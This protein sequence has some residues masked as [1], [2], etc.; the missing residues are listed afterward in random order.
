MGWFSPGGEDCGPL[1]HDIGSTVLRF[2][3]EVNHTFQRFERLISD[4]GSTLHNRKA[5]DDTAKEIDKHHDGIKQAIENARRELEE[6]E[7]TLESLR[8]VI[9]NLEFEY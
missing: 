2:N 5:N 9:V 1:L 3:G 4:L 6:A 7:Y 8:G